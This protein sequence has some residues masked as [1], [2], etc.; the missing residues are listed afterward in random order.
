MSSKE[1]ELKIKNKNQVKASQVN[2]L[3]IKT[4]LS[5]KLIRSSNFPLQMSINNQNNNSV[6]SKNPPQINR[7]LIVTK[8]DSSYA[9]DGIKDRY[10]HL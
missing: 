8:L 4:D 2:N 10:S 3:I 9:K 1:E 6:I 5:N 7:S